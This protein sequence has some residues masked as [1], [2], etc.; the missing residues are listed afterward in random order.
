MKKIILFSIFLLVCVLSY[1][2]TR[3]SNYVNNTTDYAPVYTVTPDKGDS[4]EDS[5][6]GNYIKRISD[7]DDAAASTS[8]YLSSSGSTGWAT[9]NCDGT[10]VIVHGAADSTSSAVYN[11]ESET[12]SFVADLKDNSDAIGAG[13]E[14]GHSN[15]I[16]WD[17]SESG[18][19]CSN[20]KTV[21]FIG[22]NAVRGEG[23]LFYTIGDVT[24]ID[25][26][27]SVV[28]DFTDA[29]ISWGF[30]CAIGK[31]FFR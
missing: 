20:P 29:Y 7:I 11:I 23:Y 17:M 14:I 1:A 13:N 25:N 22:N 8:N 5:N 4:I 27:I 18:E 9:E 3:S 24:D 31:R 10:M 19:T 28:H 12:P 6:Y 16:R 2:E 30:F 26:T 21:Y 15:E